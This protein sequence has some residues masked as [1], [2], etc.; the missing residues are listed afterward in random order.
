[1]KLDETMLQQRDPVGVKADLNYDADGL[2]IKDQMSEIR[3][4]EGGPEFEQI[5]DEVDIDMQSMMGI[6]DDLHFQ[7]PTKLNE[8][9]FA[10]FDLDFAED[11]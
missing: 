3:Q 10:G 8:I 5:I 11:D 6:P 4:M 2:Q 7:Q 1:M 9:K